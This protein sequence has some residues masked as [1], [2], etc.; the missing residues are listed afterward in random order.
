MLPVDGSGAALGVGARNPLGGLPASTGGI[1]AGVVV[2]GVVTT[3]DCC[4]D[5]VGVGV[6]VATGGVDRRRSHRRRWRRQAVD[7]LGVDPLTD[8]HQVVDVAGI[9]VAGLMLSMAAFVSAAPIAASSE[10]TS[11]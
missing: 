10:L 9:D 8:D 5:R 7:V 6:V 2:L 4:R 11:A 1:S 3:E